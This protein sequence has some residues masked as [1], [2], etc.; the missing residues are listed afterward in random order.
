MD[1]A[2][3]D[4]SRPF[5]EGWRSP[6]EL[7]PG[8]ALVGP[9]AGEVNRIMEIGQ[10]ADPNQQPDKGKAHCGCWTKA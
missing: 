9:E 4:H 3:S 2:A 6:G 5:L 7:P 1:P 10:Y 8:L